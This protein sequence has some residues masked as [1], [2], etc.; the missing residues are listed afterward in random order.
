MKKTVVH[1]ISAL[2]YSMIFA[3]AYASQDDY[4]Q[5]TQRFYAPS[6]AD[7]QA[8]T[9]QNT[10]TN[11]NQFTISPSTNPTNYLPDNMM[12]PYSSNPANANMQEPVTGPIELQKPENPTTQ[13]TPFEIPKANAYSQPPRITNAK[14]ADIDTTTPETNNDIDTTA[15]EAGTVEVPKIEDVSEQSNEA[16][17]P[18][19]T[20]YTQTEQPASPSGNSDAELLRAKMLANPDVMKTI[21]G[22]SNDP[23]FQEILK[24]P[25]ILKAVNSGDMHTLMSNDKF[26]SALNEPKLKEIKSQLEGEGENH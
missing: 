8:V 13:I 2:A 20:S 23:Q 15:P 12:S 3:L 24:D 14:L 1:L 10:G 6:S 5:D 16:Q 21:A 19:D 18:N 17:I 26:I 22:L 4:T 25:E 9:S 7:A 11:Q